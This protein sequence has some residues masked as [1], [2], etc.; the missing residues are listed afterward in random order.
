[1]S[2]KMKNSLQLFM[3]DKMEEATATG[4]VTIEQRDESLESGEGD[5]PKLPLSKYTQ[6]TSSIQ[7]IIKQPGKFDTRRRF[8]TV[9]PYRRKEPEI[10]P[11][12]A[13]RDTR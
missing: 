1:M 9:E 2:G 3:M 12:L 11:Q 8:K 7:L 4:Q 13:R 5:L 6:S 10:K